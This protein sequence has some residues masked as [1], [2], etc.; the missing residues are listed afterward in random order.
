MY[1]MEGD[2]RNFMVNTMRAKKGDCGVNHGSWFHVVHHR[3]VFCHSWCTPWKLNMFFMV[4]TIKGDF[5]IFVVYTS[6]W[7]I[8]DL[9][10]GLI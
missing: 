5:D 3:R 2:V 9:S 4:C 7:L 10:S 6:N 1:T 8:L